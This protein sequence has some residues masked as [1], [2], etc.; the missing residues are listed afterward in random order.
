MRKHFKFKKG[1]KSGFTLAETLVALLIL[2]M[3]T[4]IVAAGIPAASSAYT[5]VVDSANAQV[6]LS[7]TVTALR[8]QLEFA[9]EITVSGSGSEKSLTY[10]SPDNGNKSMILNGEQGVKLKEYL[11]C[12]DPVERLLVSDKAATNNLCFT[13]G[14]VSFSDGI[15]TFSDLKVVKKGN[16][17]KE[18]ASVS[19]VKF[20]VLTT[21]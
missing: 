19:S 1:G 5:K 18:L 17:D 6:L 8:N 4:S 10:I 3:V 15:V 21:G 9:R 2:L 14:D 20:R 16:T 12:I 13:Y 11:D 7:T